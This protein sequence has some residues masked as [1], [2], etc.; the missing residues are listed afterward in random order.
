MYRNGI[1]RGPSH[2]Q[3][4][5]AHMGAAC[6]GNQILGPVTDANMRIYIFQKNIKNTGN[7][8]T[9]HLQT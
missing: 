6:W 1:R 9:Q 2:G 4:Q 3:R 5:H 7:V 8:F